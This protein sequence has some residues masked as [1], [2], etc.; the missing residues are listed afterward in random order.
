MEG[1]IDKLAKRGIKI[2]TF[3]PELER[4]VT[5]MNREERYNVTSALRR[6]SQAPFLHVL[7]AVCIAIFWV[8]FAFDLWI[9]FIT[10]YT[11]AA[12]LCLLITHIFLTTKLMHYGHI[13]EVHAEER[14]MIWVAMD[15]TKKPPYVSGMI[16][17]QPLSPTHAK[18]VRFLVRS[19]Y[20]GM[21][22]GR[23]LLDTA[24]QFAVD[25]GYEAVEAVLLNLSGVKVF[26]I[27]SRRGFQKYQTSWAPSSWIPIYKTEVLKKDLKSNYLVHSVR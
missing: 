16:G 2:Q 15:V 19:S 8:T 18:L 1:T 10:G 5:Q 7:A 11:L 13:A 25:E 4:I 20:R 26:P 6:G 21:G 22:I 14:G 17:I 9:A 3:R 12:V 23:L 27:Y 24:L